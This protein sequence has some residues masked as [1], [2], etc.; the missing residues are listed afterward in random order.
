MTSRSCG[1]EYDRE[2]LRKYY[3]NRGYY[4]FRVNSSVA[5]LQTDQRNFAVTY[6]IDEG[7][8]YKFGRLRVT[9]DLKRLNANVLRQLLPIHEGQVYASDR[10]E[11][12]VDSLT[13]AAGA[14]GFAFVV[15]SGGLGI[16]PFMR[17]EIESLHCAQA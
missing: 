5:E 6:T 8:K 17:K 2:Q 7:A 13:F 4:D 3:S 14:S 10:I 16:L 15:I 11:Q 12:A 9:T 1:V